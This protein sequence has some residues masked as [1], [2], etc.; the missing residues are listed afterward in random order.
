[1]R[2]IGGPGELRRGLGGASGIVARCR[3]V[4][5]PLGF[6]IEPAQ[7]EQ[8]HFGIVEHRL[9]LAARRLV[10]AFKQRG[11]RVEQ[12]DQRLLVGALISLAACLFILRASAP[13]PAPAAIMPVD[14]A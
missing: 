13:S 6:E 5:E 10:I 9:E 12:L 7:A 2:R 14:S 8:P 3:A 1:M 4:A 11:L